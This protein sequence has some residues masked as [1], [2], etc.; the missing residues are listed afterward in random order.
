MEF[1][2]KTG[3]AERDRRQK[4]QSQVIHEKRGEAK[5]R[6]MNPISRA[7]ADVRNRAPRE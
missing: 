4:V 5:K 7:A 1:M 3:F 6:A 2:K